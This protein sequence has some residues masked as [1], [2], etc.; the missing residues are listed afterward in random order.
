MYPVRPN[1]DHI[2]PLIFA[3]GIFLVVKTVSSWDVDEDVHCKKDGVNTKVP[4]LKAKQK[5]MTAT[6]QRG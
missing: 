4:T 3:A 5:A 1:T 2:H 6:K